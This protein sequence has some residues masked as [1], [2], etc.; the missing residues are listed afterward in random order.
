MPLNKSSKFLLSLVFS[1]AALLGAGCDTETQQ[2]VLPPQTQPPAQIA[3]ETR[4]EIAVTKETATNEIP[5]SVKTL[6]NCSLPPIWG[7]VENIFKD[8]QMKE[9]EKGSGYE[10]NFNP[11]GA[12]GIFNYCNTLV[13]RHYQT[14]EGDMYTYEKVRYTHLPVSEAGEYRVAK[15]LFDGITNSRLCVGAQNRWGDLSDDDLSSDLFPSRNNKIGRD[16]PNVGVLSD[17]KNAESSGGSNPILPKE[18]VND[19]QSYPY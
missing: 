12:N 15:K 5:S 8:C 6:S 4:T 10:D 2:A 18:E 16:L 3:P 19:G 17:T 11:E 1:F 7:E 9:V 13:F 14:K